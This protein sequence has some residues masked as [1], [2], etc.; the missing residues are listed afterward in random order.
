[1]QD[2]G[3]RKTLGWGLGLL[4]LMSQINNLTVF[5]S[6]KSKSS[7]EQIAPKHCQAWP[8]KVKKKKSSNK[9]KKLL[10]PKEFK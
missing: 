4:T 9:P 7:Q 2:K 10:K 6:N 1:M 5:N 3:S 8:P